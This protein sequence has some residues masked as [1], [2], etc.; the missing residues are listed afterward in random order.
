VLA[1][2]CYTVA[3][4]PRLDE[5]SLRDTSGIEVRV[6]DARRIQ[7]GVRVGCLA[8]NQAEREAA[9]VVFGVEIK[10]ADGRVLA[11]NSLRNVLALPPGECQTA[12]LHVPTMTDIPPAFQAVAR[13][14]LVRWQ[15]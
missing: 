1:A 14:S 7:R 15:E 5:A 10:T 2:W 12:Q 9:S 11:A 4:G 13:V 6:T 8:E 3:R